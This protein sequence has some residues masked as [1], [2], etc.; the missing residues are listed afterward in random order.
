MAVL[1]IWV[2]S[3]MPE[4]GLRRAV[5]ARGAQ[6]LLL[7]LQQALMVAAAGVAAG[8]WFGASVWN[9]LP[10][11]LRGAGTWDT[12][13]LILAA[14]AADNYSLKTSALA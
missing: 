10:T 2:R 3:L 4:L 5:G 1:L 6:T 12:R 14:W 7:V 9:A 11:I 8:A 13:E